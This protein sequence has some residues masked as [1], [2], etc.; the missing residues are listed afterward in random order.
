MNT[1][2]KPVQVRIHP[3]TDF[4]PERRTKPAA[5]WAYFVYA[6]WTFVSKGVLAMGY[7]AIISEGLRLLVPALGQKLY[8]LPMLAVLREYEATY[9]LDLAPFFAFFLLIAV[10]GLWPKIID[11]WISERGRC[12][13]EERLIVALG[14]AI[15]VADAVLF[16]SAVTQMT[17]G[18]SALSFSALVAT[19]AYVG[20]VVFVSWVSVKL[21]PR[22]KDG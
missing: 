17:W 11:I 18:G 2:A 22:R 15:L 20:I 6:V 10:F 9:R 5:I 14:G 8:K 1:T 13:R 7:L 19:A 3:R 12:N 16:Y 4:I 21:N